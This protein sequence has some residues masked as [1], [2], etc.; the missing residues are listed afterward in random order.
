MAYDVNKLAR[1]KDLK[2]A[3]AKTKADYEAKIKAITVPAYDLVKDETSGDFAAVYHLTK[4]GQNVG[5]PINIPKDMVVSDGAVVENPDDEHQGTFIKLV[6]QNVKDPLYIDVGGLIEYVTSGSEK[7][8]MVFVTVDPTSHKVTATITDGT[9]TKAKL[10]DSVQKTLDAVANKVDKEDGK[11]LS[12]NDYTTA[13]KEKL[14]G[15]STGAT[16]V[17]ASDTNG[18][19]KIDGVETTVYTEPDDVVHGAIAADADVTEML[20]E[21]FGTAE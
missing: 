18:N 20:N 5:V 10:E 11:G 3:A 7:G 1:L 17:A 19:I 6:L 2:A 4:D 12:T 21:V 8:D 9:I 13:E 16:K 14:A 15:I